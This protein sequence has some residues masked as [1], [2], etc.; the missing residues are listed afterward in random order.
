MTPFLR[1]FVHISLL[2]LLGLIA[3][4]L[5]SLAQ[6]A[7]PDTRDVQLDALHE[8]N[9]A[10]QHRLAQQTAELE[11]YRRGLER[12]VD[13]LNRIRARRRDDTAPTSAKTQNTDAPGTPVQNPSEMLMYRFER[14]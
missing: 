7:P 12:A 5:A 1:S 3:W 11:R 10:L 13:E 9:L 14:C 6:A 2:L 8:Q 4:P